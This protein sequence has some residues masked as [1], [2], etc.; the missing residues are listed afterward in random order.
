[1]SLNSS[2]ADFSLAELFQI[3]DQGRRS[4]CLIV[5]NLLNYNASAGQSRYYFIWFR[6]G[7]IV[8]ASNCLDGRGLI[9]QI[10]QRKLVQPQVID[11]F[12]SL[13]PKEIPLGLHLKTAGLLD[14]E[15]LNLLFASQLQQIR[16]LFEI[17]KGVFKLDSKAPIPRKEMTGLSL[18]AI[19]VALM[20]LRTLK[21]WETLADALPD[22]SSA[23]CSITQNKPHVHLKTLEWQVWEFANGN[24]S[25]GAIANQLNQSTALVQ[26]AAFR[27]MIAGLVEEV[28]LATSTLELSD[29]P[30]DVNSVNS[31]SLANKKTQ[32]PEMLNI[33]ASFLHNLVG[34]LKSNIS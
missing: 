7:C 10:K 14:A 24:V 23:I 30:L 22:V 4:G 31:S 3:I 13:A 8:A 12:C 19:E 1:M 21:N 11:K 28:P 27:L 34:Y 9:G 17:Q 6:Q 26:Q 25:L 20:A 5:C 16:K 33:S 29:Y 18:R 15:H 2:L 32:E